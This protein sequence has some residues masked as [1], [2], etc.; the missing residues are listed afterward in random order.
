MTTNDEIEP[1]RLIKATRR[2]LRPTAEIIQAIA[3][4]DSEELAC[5]ASINLGKIGDPL[6]LEVLS[7][8]LEKFSHRSEPIAAIGFLKDSTPVPQLI[9]LLQ[10]QDFPF[11]EEIVRVLGEIADPQAGSTL[12]DLLHDVERMVRY[13]AAWALYKLGGRDVVHSLCSLLSDPDEWIVVNALEIISRLK[14]PEAIPP[15]VGQFKI[16]QDPRL[17]AIIISALGAFSE[18][19]LLPIF[20]EGLKSF[21][22]RIQ[23]N[24]VEAISRLKISPLEVKRKLKKFIS[25]S[26]NRVRANT[27]VAIFR[28]DPGKALEEIEEMIKSP[29]LPT[30]RSAA[31]V[32][33]KINVE[34]RSELIGRLLADSAFGVRKMALKA[35]L[36]LSTDVGIGRIIP[37][38]KDKNQWVRKE[39]VDCTRKIDDMP[40]E[41]LLD[42]FRLE[43]S[44]PV[45]ES[46]LD[47]FVEKRGS[48]AIPMIL[49]KV[50][51]KPE[52]G[53][54]K[55]LYSLGKLNAINELREAR[56]YF[57]AD[58]FS[59][60]KEYFIAL[61][62]NGDLGVFED[63]K[64]FLIN[65]K[66]EEDRIGV[67]EVVGDVGLFL[68]K[69]ENYSKVL[70]E[71]LFQEAKKDMA[72]IVEFAEPEPPKKEMT[73]EDGIGLLNTGKIK[74]AE[75]FFIGFL[76][77]S[78]LNIDALFQFGSVLIKLGKFPEAVNNLEKIIQI[79]PGHLQASL[80]AG[81][82][83]FQLRNWDKLVE[84]YEKIRNMIPETEKKAVCQ[85][86]GAL[87][88]A[89]YNQKRYQKALEFLRKALAINPADLSSTY[90]LALTLINLRQNSEALK[91]LKNLKNNI[92]PDSR[93]LKNIE[94]LL[95]KLEEE[96]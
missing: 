16:V 26:N 59:V 71:Q 38:L 23:A 64:N 91:I 4:S 30:R 66:R 44:P 51:T 72:G 61:L 82:I 62:L 17:K 32:L 7:D 80:L 63:L 89:Y 93:F 20:E 81:Q 40:V 34:K 2:L 88:L 39:A 69:T 50:K 48:A 96:D 83:Y 68:R 85:V 53:L 87:G 47:F 56:K 94:E 1:F 3:Q 42:A 18:G 37:L 73:L 74:E 22:S 10:V 29:D 76:D 77:K 27:A 70:A 28:A 58:D 55:L 41:P 13:Y 86:Q 67:L 25:H 92:P 45:L 6:F 24:A 75:R 90:H 49:Q 60:M 21:D 57:E 14:D 5:Q 52:E 9:K 12:K 11:K 84:I 8:N 31:Y 35:A 43:N 95:L 19:N 46:M 78:P 33:S 65:Q 15:L 36:S 79:N 54:S